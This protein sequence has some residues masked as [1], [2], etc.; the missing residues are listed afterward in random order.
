MLKLFIENNKELVKD[1]K[2]YYERRTS[3]YDDTTT[4][5]GF[6]NALS[7]IAILVGTIYSIDYIIDHSTAEPIL[8]IVALVC[9]FIALGATVCYIVVSEKV[10]NK[11]YDQTD[12]LMVPVS[13]Y[14]GAVCSGSIAVLFAIIFV[15]DFMSFIVYYIPRFFIHKLCNILNNHISKKSD[16]PAIKAGVENMQ[17]QYNNFLK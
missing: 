3:S 12:A 5:F 11:K 6:I 9:E 10:Q 14:I 8:G 7:F 4:V 17:Q 15:I 2:R 16:N 13:L 1:P